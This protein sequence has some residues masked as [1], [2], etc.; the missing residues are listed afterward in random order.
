MYY[1]VPVTSS[2]AA[3]K[4]RY[5]SVLYYSYSWET[6]QPLA[7][8]VT[9]KWM[10]HRNLSVNHVLRMVSELFSKPSFSVERT[11]PWDSCMAF[12][13]CPCTSGSPSCCLPSSTLQSKLR[14]T[15][16]GSLQLHAQDLQLLSKIFYCYSHSPALLWKSPGSQ[17]PPQ[18]KSIFCISFPP[19]CHS[20]SLMM[21]CIFL[22]SRYR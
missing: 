15:L 1:W 21:N 16:S 5:S 22:C 11:Q 9:S 12:E 7:F 20:T 8:S 19:N 10:A 4:P 17:S 14:P 3:L 2:P 13:L 18:G 6:S